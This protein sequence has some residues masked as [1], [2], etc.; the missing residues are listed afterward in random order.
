MQ[1]KQLVPRPVVLC[2]VAAS[3][4]FIAIHV[5]VILAIR[6]VNE[7]GLKNVVNEVREG[8]D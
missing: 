6:E 3:L 7:T 1:I 5:V 4:I 8:K 2:R